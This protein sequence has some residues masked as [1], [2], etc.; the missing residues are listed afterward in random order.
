[1]RRE[2]W[3]LIAAFVA[4]LLIIVIQSVFYAKLDADLVARAAELGHR[5]PVEEY[6]RIQAQFAGNVLVEVLGQLLLGLP[7]FAL[8]ALG[9]AR[10]RQSL[11]SVAAQRLISVAW[12]CAL[13]AL[14]AW[15]VQLY[16]DLSIKFGPGRW[17]PLG[18]LFDL[19]YSPFAFATAFLGLGAVMCTAL[20]LR[21]RG[22]TP[23]MS[24]VALIV[25]ALLVVANAAAAIATGFADGLP[26]LI[27]LIP[28][29]MLGLDLVRA[30]QA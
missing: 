7:P 27:P 24:L 11:Q 22:I 26:P 10:I 1:M 28:A 12:W 29:L 6:S 15:I 30:R 20:A 9:V 19:L 23:R 17:W 21:K 18:S 3:L 13:G 16:L 5:P 4:G 8:L 14:A 25:A 2:G